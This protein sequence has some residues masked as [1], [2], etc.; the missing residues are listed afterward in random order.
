MKAE[1]VLLDG[2]YR[3]IPLDEGTELTIGTSAQSVVR[4]TAVDVSRSHALIT[5]QRGK[6]SLLDLG[7]TNGTFVNG[8]RVKES[9]LGPGD[10]I[11]FSSV[12][13]QVM[14]LG[15]SSSGADN[16]P[17]PTSTLRLSPQQE[18]TS[19]SGEVPI[20]LQDTLLWLL[21]RWVVSDSDPLMSLV[22]WLVERRG[23]KGA[24][25]AE[26]VGGE[27]SL[28]GAHGGLRDVL[29]DPKLGAVVKPSSSPDGG[30]ETTQTILGAHKVVA[31][32]GAS[33]P[34]LLLLPGS[35]MPASS[36]IELFVALLRVAIRLE[37]RS[38][39]S[40]RRAR[41]AGPR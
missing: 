19:G 17:S 2:S 8:R 28:L 37:A 6:L 9:E 1:L 30:L 18:V 39:G 15:S 26:A 3:R 27:I 38:G 14:P 11:R 36:D 29:D 12:I 7:S 41:A 21:Q 25:L 33:L 40:P 34:C 4:L 32:H 31:V 23:M 35:G 13:A 16:P 24:A 20:I 22:E 10:V 5:C